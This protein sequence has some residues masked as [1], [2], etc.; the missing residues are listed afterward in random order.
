MTLTKHQ[1]RLLLVAYCAVIVVSVFWVAHGSKP[2][3]MG[4]V[5]E[6]KRRFGMETW[7]DYDFAVFMLWLTGTILAAGLVGLVFV[8]LLRREGLY[9]FLI[10]VCARFGYYQLRYQHPSMDFLSWVTLLFEVS[11][12]ALGLFGPAKHLFQRQREI[13]I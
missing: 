5:A 6:A 2:L 4:D 1:F 10:A 3:T 7:T 12:I 9:I 8:F 13:R 11:I